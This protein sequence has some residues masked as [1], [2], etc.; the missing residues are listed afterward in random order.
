MSPNRFPLAHKAKQNGRHFHDNLTLEPLVSEPKPVPPGSHS[1][2]K[3]PLFPF[4]PSHLPLV[5]E[6]KPVPPVLTQ[7]NKMAT[8]S[9]LT[10]T[11]EPLV[12]EPKT[13]LPG[14]SSQTK[15]PPSPY[16]PSHLSPWWMSPLADMAKQNG[17]HLPTYPHT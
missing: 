12:D 6:P 3:W 11:L 5:D 16:L 9:L 13:V 15:W 17:R 14:S 1:Q 2:T 4:L 8:I 7:Q 10:L